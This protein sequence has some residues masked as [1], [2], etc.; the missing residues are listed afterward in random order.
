[1]VKKKSQPYHVRL[2]EYEEEKRRINHDVS[3]TA[4]EYESKMAAL[5]K[6]LKI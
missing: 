1:M 4:M 6:R 3:L 5:A 2:R